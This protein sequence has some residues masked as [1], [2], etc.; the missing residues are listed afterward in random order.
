MEGPSSRPSWL[1]HRRDREPPTPPAPPIAGA[2]KR[3]PP[4]EQSSG[5]HRARVRCSTDLAGWPH[6]TE[7]RHRAGEGQDR[8]AEPR[9]QHP[10]P[11]D[12]GAVG[13][14][15]KDESARSAQTGAWAHSF[16]TNQESE[17]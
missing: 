12:A 13:C 8:L 16:T 14:R 2:G 4:E 6:R 9:L 3:E 1:E 7:D 15:I 11:C 10:P 5:P 17:K